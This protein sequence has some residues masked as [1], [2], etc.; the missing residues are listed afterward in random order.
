M[1]TKAELLERLRTARLDYESCGSWNWKALDDL[2][3]WAESLPNDVPQDGAKESADKPS[4]DTVQP[5][6]DVALRMWFEG[7]L[8]RTVPQRV[9]LAFNFTDLIRAKKEKEAGK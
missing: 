9:D 1:I 5:E 7:K 4:Q 2:D 8:N 3:N 6:L